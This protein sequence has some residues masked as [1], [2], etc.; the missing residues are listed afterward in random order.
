MV[1]CR[2]RSHRA[3]A[4]GIPTA[5]TPRSTA[6]AYQIIRCSAWSGA[7]SPSSSPAARVIT[8]PVAAM[9]IRHFCPVTRWKQ[10]VNSMP[11]KAIFKNSAPTQMAVATMSSR[12]IT[13]TCT[14]VSTV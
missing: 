7:A 4:A 9:S 6:E 3:S 11:K 14:V 13:L 12:C 1:L 10:S 2:Q 5:H 8:A